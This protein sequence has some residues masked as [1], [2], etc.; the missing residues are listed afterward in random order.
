M[1]DP[2]ESTGK[3]KPVSDRVL[4][5]DDE[6]DILASLRVSL[7]QAG[8]SEVHTESDPERA[9]ARVQEEPWS[10]VVLDLMMP[11][12]H[13]SQV[14]EALLEAQPQAEAIVLT[15]VN[16]APIAVSALRLGAF[17]YLVKPVDG[18]DLAEVVRRALERHAPADVR[19][20]KLANPEAF[21]GFLTASPKVIR[22]LRYLERV[23][24]TDECVL[25][26]GPSGTGKE[27]VARAIHRLSPRRDGPFLGVNVSAIPES[28]FSSHL[29]GH[30]AGAFSGATSARRGF[31]SEARGG[32][33][34]LDE[35]GELEL[36]LQAKLL[37]VLQ[38][39]EYYVV[40]ES[41]PTALDTR[42]VVASNRDLEREVEAG[43]FR[44]DLF[45]RI[46]AT[47]VRIPPLAERP[48]DLPLLI[49]HYVARLAEQLGQDVRRVLPRTLELLSGY[50]YP[51][52]VRE[53]Q[54]ILRE[55]VLK[56]DGPELRP[57]SLPAK[58]TQNRL[59]VTLPQG[60]CKPLEEVEQEHILRA[61]EV[62]KGNASH[63]AELLGISRATLNRRLRAYRR[64]G[65]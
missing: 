19:K 45:Y 29:F 57:G 63:A 4:L 49:D 38:E 31:F 10:A 8:F 16:D 25:I 44:S 51:G 54:N 56:E 23:A 41:R 58:C 60:A 65:R 34:F 37:R 36:S 30:L 20:A 14:L 33:L 39:R 48:E 59:R 28:L 5:V 62:T 46:S 61:L 43:R 6:Q 35:I 15:A 17:D 53:L 52:N 27:L 1:A 50:G 26:S 9:L 32:T 2:L 55:A 24:P 21:E 47:A 12:V 13:G 40:G 64:Q 3:G 7:L 18:G 42:L 22:V 11:R